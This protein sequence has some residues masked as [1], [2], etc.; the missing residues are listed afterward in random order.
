MTLQILGLLFLL[1]LFSCPTAT[2]EEKQ[3][4]QFSNEA[5]ATKNFK[6]KTYIDTVNIGFVLTFQYP[7]NLVAESIENGRCVGEPIKPEVVDGSVT[8]TMRW[9]VWM[10]DTTESQPIDSLIH[11][12]KYFFKGHVT[13]LRETITVQ[14]IK[15]IRVTLTSD[16]KNDP[17]RQIIYLKKH[18]TLFE[19]INNYS[20]D[21]DFEI[22]YKSFTVNEYKKPSH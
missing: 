1:E 20:A 9:C 14:G 17:Y 13:E 4:A 12:E 7:D 5:T 10:N 3:T 2:T 8:N 15:A 22:F 18:S 21:K 19:I 6:W 16:N 11:S